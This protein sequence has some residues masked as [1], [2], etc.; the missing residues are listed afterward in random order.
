[1]SSWGFRNP[2]SAPSSSSPSFASSF[3]MQRVGY[4]RVDTAASDQTEG[5]ERRR[6]QQRQPHHPTHSYTLADSIPDTAIDGTSTMDLDTHLLIAQLALADLAQFKSTSLKYKQSVLKASTDNEFAVNEQE[7][8]LTNLVRYL[9]DIKLAAS[10]DRAI[11]SDRDMLERFQW[12]EVSEAADRMAAAVLEEGGELP[13]ETRAQRVVGSKEFRLQET[14]RKEVAA[15]SATSSKATASTSKPKEIRV[16]CIG[17]T[18]NVIKSQCIIGACTHAYCRECIISLVEACIKDE[19]LYPLKCC[20]QEFPVRNIVLLLGVKL[21]LAFEEKCKEYRVP[22]NRRVYCSNP[23]C[24]AFLGSSEDEAEE[25]VCGRCRTI[26]CTGCKE[27]AHPYDSCQEH[28]DIIKVKEIAQREGWQTCPGCKSIVELNLGCYHMT[29]RCR[30]EFCYL[31][32][33]RWKNCLCPQWDEER[34]LVDAQ[35]RVENEIGQEVRHVAPQLF[36]EQVMW[37]V[38]ELRENHDCEVHSWKNRQGGGECENCG[39]YLPIFLKICRHCYM[40]ACRRCALNRL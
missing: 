31:C 10:I 25:V 35:R 23:R 21:R 5:W 17:C 18:E 36:E 32:A 1:M 4:A 37:R 34:L 27:A 12:L 40:L 29:C 26:T 22:A 19:T 7:R 28:S 11:E 16:E 38:E 2:T 3:G 15:R 9:Q 30:T 33:V 39:D 6:Q 20:K 13:A 24:S 14:A 8:E